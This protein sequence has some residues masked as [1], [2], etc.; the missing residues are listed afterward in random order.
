MGKL[1]FLG[2]TLSSRANIDEEVNSRIA[3]ASS[4]LGRIRCSVW[5]GRGIGLCI[6]LNVYQVVAKLFLTVDITVFCAGESWTVY[7]IHA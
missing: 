7:K 6:K 5:K 3:T 1:T 2:S 4:D